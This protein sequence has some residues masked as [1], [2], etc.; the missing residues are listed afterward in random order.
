MRNNL[1]HLI[2]KVV[3]AE[4]PTEYVLILVDHLTAIVV[5]VVL[6]TSPQHQN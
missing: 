5:V 3:V 2:P 1:P 6:D 4:E